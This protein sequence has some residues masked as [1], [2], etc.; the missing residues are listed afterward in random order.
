MIKVLLYNTDNDKECII[1]LPAIPRIGD[2][3]DISSL[4]GVD[5]FM[6]EDSDYIMEVES[7]KFFPNSDIVNLYITS[8]WNKL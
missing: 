5:D 3:I 1:Q 7:V 4:E 8:D 2:D 6:H